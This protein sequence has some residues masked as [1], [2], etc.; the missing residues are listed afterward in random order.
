MAFFFLLL[1]LFLSLVRDIGGRETMDE[2]LSVGGGIPFRPIFSASRHL[3][4]PP[5]FEGGE[6]LPAKKGHP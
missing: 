1:L 5:P 2:F 6:K 4:C 3:E